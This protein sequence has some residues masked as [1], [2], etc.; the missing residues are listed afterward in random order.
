MRSLKSRD[1]C[2]VRR[3]FTIIIL[4]F[5]P[6]ALKAQFENFRDSVVQ[7]YGVVMSADSLRA[8]PAASVVILSQNRG[9]ITNDQGV[10]SIVALKG[11]R[12]EF[13]SVGYKPVVITIPSNIAGNQYSVVQLM[14]EDTAFLPV[15]IIKARPTKEQF[16]RDFA[17]AD[18]RDDDI[19]KARQANNAET[20]R[21]LAAALPADAREAGN[22]FLN[23]QAY[24]A[25]YYRQLPPQNILNPLA[26]AEFI[27]AWKRGDFKKKK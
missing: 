24:K 4:L 18:I 23:Q 8:V 12:V 9:T 5:A 1:Y 20:R 15:T 7:L 6:F 19:E 26:W 10:F 25:T 11:D 16:A 27:R 3:I 22:V 17:N 2:C 21:M 14:T 13:T